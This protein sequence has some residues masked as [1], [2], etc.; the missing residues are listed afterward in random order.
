MPSR[1]IGALGTYGSVLVPDNDPA[2]I[3]FRGYKP[4]L[5]KKAAQMSIHGATNYLLRRV[6]FGGKKNDDQGRSW[7]CRS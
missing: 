5:L 7:K 4:F 3:R 1:L 6:R 2:K